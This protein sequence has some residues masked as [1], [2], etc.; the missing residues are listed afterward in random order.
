M[1]RTGADGERDG[2]DSP[3]LFFPKNSQNRA[4]IDNTG[5]DKTCVFILL[6]KLLLDHH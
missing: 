5:Q 2:G 3:K 1:K 4:E 6:N